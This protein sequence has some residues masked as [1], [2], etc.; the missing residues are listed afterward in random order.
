MRRRLPL[1]LL[2]LV[3]LAV[4]FFFTGLAAVVDGRMNRLTTPPPYRASPAATEMLRRLE[5]VDLHADAL[6]W[7]R[8]LL[9]RNTRGHVDLPRLREGHVTLQVFSAVTKTPRGLNYERNDG[10]TDNVTLLA[11]AQRYPFRAWFSLR[12]R[13]QWQAA[14]LAAAVQESAPPGGTPGLVLVRSVR[15]LDSL[16]A[17]RAGGGDAPVG[18]LLATEGLHPLEGRLEN[19]DTLM[20][21]GYRMFG[22]TH[23][24]D[25]EVGGS[26]HGVAK[27]GLTPFGRAVVDRLDSLGGIIDLAHASQPLLDDVLAHTRRPVVVSHTGVQGTCPGVRNLSDL[28]L[29]RIAA[30]GGVVGIG[31]WD[32]AVCDVSPVGVARAIAYA[33]RVAG[34]DHVALGSD[35]D[36]ATTTPFDATGSAQLVEALQGAGLS[37]SQIGKVMGK[38]ALALLR[39]LLTP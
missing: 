25:N 37:E 11:M 19:L 8:D 18:A 24:F 12:E 27:G 1:A 2:L 4:T 28:Q 9:T 33:V 14:R 6:L 26:A 5:V 36:G 34:D 21:A 38:N 31:Y 35:F 32:A 10:S 13:A 39:R 3:L 7:P 20:A 16:L 22:F 15:D 30:G 29:R 23:F 17:A